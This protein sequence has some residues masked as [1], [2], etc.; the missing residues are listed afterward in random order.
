MTA[1]SI[2]TRTVV[3]LTVVHAQA[4]HFCDEARAVIDGLAER[5]PVRVEYVAAEG[6]RGRALV[7]A[8]RA[9]MYPRVLVD[10]RFFS[11]GRLP[12]RKLAKALDARTGAVA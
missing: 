6:E 3:D 8:H 9:P 10:G 4:C 11:A 7:A 12:R 1:T 2:A 5:Y